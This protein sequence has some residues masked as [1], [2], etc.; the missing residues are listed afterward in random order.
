MCFVPLSIEIPIISVSAFG[1]WFSVGDR[2]QETRGVIQQ[3]LEA[4]AFKSFELLARKK[5]ER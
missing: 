1:D 2:S 5:R 3:Q 4:N